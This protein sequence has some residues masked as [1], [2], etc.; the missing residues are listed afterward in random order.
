MIDQLNRLKAS[1]SQD[2]ADTAKRYSNKVSKAARNAV[3]ALLKIDS[4]ITIKRIA[5]VTG[6]NEDYITKTTRELRNDDLITGE[7][8]PSNLYCLIYKIKD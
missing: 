3:L 5:K 1:V 2:G 7:K 4:G 8:N 6:Y